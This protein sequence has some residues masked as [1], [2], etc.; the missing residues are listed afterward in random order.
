MSK[1]KLSLNQ[2]ADSSQTN[3]DNFAGYSKSLRADAKQNKEQILE[4]AY[5]IFTEKGLAVPIGE[6]A[7]EAGVGVGTI[8]RHFP[9]KEVLF[10]AVILSYKQRLT[11]EANSLMNHVDPGKAF[12]DLFSRI[13]EEGFTN[14]AWKDAFKNGTLNNGT[15]NSV[16][17]QDFQSAYTNLLV[18]A[19]KAKAVREDIDIKDLI[20][21]ISCLLLAL[22]QQGDAPNID[23][24]QRLISIAIDGLRYKEL[25]VNQNE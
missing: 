25:A 9:T 11:A 5:K 6:I 12:F 17:L 8:Y 16:V 21:L 1:K 20:T 3:E 22:D 4:A 14:R 13:L 23:R 7:R 10:E 15:T 2:T 19:Q 24:F 18:R